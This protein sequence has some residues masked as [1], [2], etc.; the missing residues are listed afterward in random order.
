MKQGD[1]IAYMNACGKIKQATVAET[2]LETPHNIRIFNMPLNKSSESYVLGLKQQKIFGFRVKD[3]WDYYVTGKVLKKKEK[4][5]L[6][7]LIE[8]MRPLSDIH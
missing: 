1:I 5:L 3:P 7:N 2:Y 8:K 4:N 6:E